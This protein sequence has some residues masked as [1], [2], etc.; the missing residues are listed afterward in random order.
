MM[1][2]ACLISSF[3]NKTV[4]ICL[5][6]CIHLCLL[7]NY[8]H[9][10]SFF[11]L[12]LQSKSCIIKP[13]KRLKQRYSDSYVFTQHTLYYLLCHHPSP[14]QRDKRVILDF[15]SLTILIGVEL[16]KKMMSIYIKCVY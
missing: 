5:F 3:C 8:A 6:R 16:K 1:F 2:R 9:S 15:Y 12:K 10:Y 4:A 11:P 13:K 14:F 7:Y